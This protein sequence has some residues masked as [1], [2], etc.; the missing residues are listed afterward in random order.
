M[1]QSEVKIISEKN[2]VLVSSKTESV[3]IIK[4]QIKV[5]VPTLKMV[6]RVLEIDK[7]MEKVD[8]DAKVELSEKER[9]AL[10]KSVREEYR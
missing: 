6:E 1:I 7:Y 2:S 10:R 3:K 8:V 9:T 5:Y 4:E